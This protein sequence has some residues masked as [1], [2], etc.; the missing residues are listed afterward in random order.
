MGKNKVL[1]TGGHHTSALAVIDWL[2]KNSKNI[3]IVWVGRK[4]L[5]GMQTIEYKDV[6][7]R[8]I[9]FYDLE[10]GKLYRIRS[11]KYIFRFLNGLYLIPSGIYKAYLI[12]KKEQPDLIL[13]FGGYLSVP[14]VFMGYLHNIKIIVHEQ[15]VTIGLANK[16]NSYFVD[17]IFTSWP[18]SYYQC[19]HRI[20]SKLK[21]SGMPVRE[22]V[23]KFSKTLSSKILIN[24]SLKT[25]LVMGGKEGAEYL[26]NFI[27]SNASELLTEF[28]IILQTGSKPYDRK[29]L[30]KIIA[31]NTN[32]MLIQKDYL[33]DNEIGTYYRI[34]DF[35]IS[36][37]GGH[38]IY[39]LITINKR[40]ILIPLEISSGN[41]QLKNA[42]LAKK[43]GIAEIFREKDSGRMDLLKYI[44]NFSKIYSRMKLS[45][46]FD[47]SI[48]GQV[49]LG[50][51]I[52]K[53]F[54]SS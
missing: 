47:G 25:I 43:L 49:I 54:K 23:K 38:F 35:I 53:Y 28:N 46:I 18:V 10:A 5:N 36:R 52:I 2:T 7:N 15:T 13:A 51:E 45:P 50:N 20:K 33:L 17:T 30:H 26:N 12:I 1:I 44:F 8:K 11:I 9:K 32:G 27:I 29:A 39:D 22:E 21:F 16:I 34:C 41:E 37:S 31:A 40:A 3:V 42:V 48:K 24:S 14:L 6:L 4:Y 19:S